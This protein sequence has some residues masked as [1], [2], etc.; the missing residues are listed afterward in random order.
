MADPT[1]AATPM[2]DSDHPAVIEYAQ[3]HAVGD[4]ARDRAVALFYAVRDD[5]RYD[6]YRIDVSV[7]G[8]K[9]STVIRNGY[10]WC[11]PKATL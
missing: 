7:E 4:S 1:L 10:G 2:I 11:V 6:P 8:M 3:Q 5:F 9:A